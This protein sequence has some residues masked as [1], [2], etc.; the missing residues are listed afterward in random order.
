ML[1]AIVRFSLRFRG[2]II[3]LALASLG[4]G[5]YTLTQAKYVVFPE[6]APPRV[7][8]QTEAPGLSPEQVELLVTQPIENAINGVT[9]IDS[10][11]SSSI[12]GL[13][14]INV[15]FQTGNDVY[16]ERQ[17]VAERLSTLAGQLPSGVKAPI[18]TPL[19][20][21][22]SNV[23]ILG[24]T[25]NRQSLMQLRT[26]ADWTLRPRLLA[27]PGVAS[28]TVFGGETRQIQVQFHPEKLACIIHEG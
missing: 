2:V 16:L 5:L 4:Y 23:L 27:V 21:S 6:F 1:N 25:S 14:V 10:L 20:S 7:S 9:G 18:M 24:L 8:I 13:S 22:T 15:V 28:V 12:Q 17:F 26:A 11:R 19:T 3:S